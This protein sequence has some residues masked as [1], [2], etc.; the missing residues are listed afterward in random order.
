MERASPGDRLAVG[1]AHSEEARSVRSIFHQKHDVPR[2]YARE[3]C[4]T[5]S[6]GSLLPEGEAFPAIGPGC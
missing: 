4:V 3:E 2:A 6:G 1:A 5:L